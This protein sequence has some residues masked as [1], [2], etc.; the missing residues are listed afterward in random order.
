MLTLIITLP[1]CEATIH[2]ILRSR[3]L[4]MIKTKFI[5]LQFI[6]LIYVCIFTFRISASILH[7]SSEYPETSEMLEAPC[8]ALL[9]LPPGPV[10]LHTEKEQVPGIAS[11]PPGVDRG[12][13]VLG[14]GLAKA[15]TA[16]QGN[17]LNGL[18]L[19]DS[20]VFVR[21][22]NTNC[23]HHSVKKAPWAGDRALWLFSLRLHA[24]IEHQQNH[25]QMK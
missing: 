1:K 16:L 14:G 7:D 12:P 9:D 18:V 15:G 11:S 22:K 8:Q 20:G 23:S 10:V 4:P 19:G 25:L 5:G 24:E 21:L 17:S 3:M 13:R 2:L 6:Q